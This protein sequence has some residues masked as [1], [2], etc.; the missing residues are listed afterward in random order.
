MFSD[1]GRQQPA[2][3][4]PPVLIYICI[5]VVLCECLSITPV[6]MDVRGNL[7]LIWDLISSSDL[8]HLFQAGKVDLRSGPG[9][10]SAGASPRCCPLTPTTLSTMVGHGKVCLLL[11][12]IVHDYPSLLVA[13]ATPVAAATRG[14]SASRAQGGHVWG[15][16][17]AAGGG[18]QLCDLGG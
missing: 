7:I 9:A 13:A 4:V 1:G 2:G 8:Q 16:Q 3:V 14:S 15:T 6:G 11:R 5:G 12:Q 18:G 17:V 10:A